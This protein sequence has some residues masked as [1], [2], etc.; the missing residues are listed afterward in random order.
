TTADC[1]VGDIS[2]QGASLE[3]SRA[4]KLP[5]GRMSLTIARKGCLPRQNHPVARPF[6]RRCVQR[7][8]PIRTPRLRSR[9]AAAQE[10][11]EK[12]PAAAPHQKADRPRPNAEDAWRCASLRGSVIAMHSMEP[13]MAGPSDTAFHANSATRIRRRS[14]I[15]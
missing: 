10:P 11:A 9:G 14:R 5:K 1:V 12:A 15:D 7:G 13:N 6:Y 8:E 3:F 4:V 2:E